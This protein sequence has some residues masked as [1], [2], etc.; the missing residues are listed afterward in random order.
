ME[1]WREVADLVHKLLE[2]W[3]RM[4]REVLEDEEARKVMDQLTFVSFL[5]A[6]T[7]LDFSDR[8]ADEKTGGLSFVSEEE[9]VKYDEELEWVSERE[10]KRRIM[11]ES[12]AVRGRRLPRRRAWMCWTVAE[13]GEVIQ[14]MYFDD[15]RVPD[16][17]VGSTFAMI[18]S[19]G[20][21]GGGRR[22][23]KYDEAARRILEGADYEEVVQELVTEE[24]EERM[25]TSKLLREDEERSARKQIRAAL[26]RRG[27]RPH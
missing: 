3:P 25:K 8:F 17:E 4:L 14:R 18:Q 2:L 12:L 21:P 6:A 22:N 1:L 13:G 7:T 23:P 20:L 27:V 9:L 19:Y 11:P 16:S 24:V 15:G 10:T 26:R 5:L